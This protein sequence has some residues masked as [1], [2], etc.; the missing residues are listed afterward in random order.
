VQGS[1]GALPRCL[2]LWMRVVV[3]RGENPPLPSP[4]VEEPVSAAHYVDLLLV[5]AADPKLIQRN[6]A[7]PDVLKRFDKKK[8]SRFQEGF[9]I[10]QRVS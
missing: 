7:L 1:V 6:R 9:L 2:Y 10:L 3:R 4:L 8:P 5:R